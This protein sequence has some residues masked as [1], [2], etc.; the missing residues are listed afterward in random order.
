MAEDPVVISLLLPLKSADKE[1]AG[2]VRRS[3]QASIDSW[4]K[5]GCRSDEASSKGEQG[6]NY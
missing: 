4:T 6:L 3:T 1:E 5:P 2:C